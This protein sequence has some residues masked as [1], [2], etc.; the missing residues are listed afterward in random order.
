MNRTRIVTATVGTLLVGAAALFSSIAS[1]GGNVAWSVSVGGPG[2]AV[3]VG[4]P[5]YGG[6]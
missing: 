4:G 6:T 1:A 5:G 3:N 2:F